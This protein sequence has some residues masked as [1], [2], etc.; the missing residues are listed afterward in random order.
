MSS[1][2]SVPFQE[3]ESDEGGEEEKSSNADQTENMISPEKETK[4]KSS[5][6]DTE[7]D[8]EDDGNSSLTSLVR[9]EK[10]KKNV[11]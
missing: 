1:H 9:E 3:D 6:K 11:S 5:E 10:E 4:E 8:E 7:V 2:I